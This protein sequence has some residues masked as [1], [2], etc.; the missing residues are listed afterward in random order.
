[1]GRATTVGAALAQSGDGDFCDADAGGEGGMRGCGGKTEVGDDTSCVKPHWVRKSGNRRGWE[2]GGMTPAWEP[3]IIKQ[4][5]VR[6]EVK[7]RWRGYSAK[8][9]GRPGKKR[10][11]SDR[12]PPSKRTGRG[13]GPKTAHAKGKRKTEPDSNEQ[14]DSTDA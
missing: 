4:N 10:K 8:N 9:K 1:M 14:S 3:K 11:V 12:K 6:N 2:K 7:D 13:R 5:I